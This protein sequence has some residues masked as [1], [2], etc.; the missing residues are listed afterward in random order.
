M[1]PNSYTSNKRSNPWPIVRCVMVIAGLLWAISM[2]SDS[3]NQDKAGEAEA[4]LATVQ[5][6]LD[7]IAAEPDSVESADRYQIQIDALAD[8]L[9]TSRHRKDTELAF[10]FIED[11]LSDIEREMREDYFY[12]NCNAR[13][14]R[15]NRSAPGIP[16]LLIDWVP[17]EGRTAKQAA[18]CK[19]TTMQILPSDTDGL[20]VKQAGDRS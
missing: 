15:I 20:T 8:A 12:Y 6:Q 11:S 13:N 10:A 7:D 9:E 5:Q 16:V 14:I 19:G 18:I 4:K 1:Q 3:R 2:I 17:R